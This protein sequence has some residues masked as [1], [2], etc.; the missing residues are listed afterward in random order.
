MTLNETIIGENIL[1]E[2]CEEIKR[3]MWIYTTFLEATANCSA[4]HPFESDSL[5]LSSPDN[6]VIYGNIR[7]TVYRQLVTERIIFIASK[8]IKLYEI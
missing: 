2:I 7:H 4:V 8:C 1:K 3:Y 6:L 5:T